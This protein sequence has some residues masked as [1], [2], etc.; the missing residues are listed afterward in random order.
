M[1]RD[2]I[3]AR[4]TDSVLEVLL[5]RKG[6]GWWWEQEIGA[7]NRAQIKRKLDSAIKEELDRPPIEE[8]VG[9]SWDQE[10]KIAFRKEWDARVVAARTA[11][12]EPPVA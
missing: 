2:S 8:A 9:A 7:Y 3:E 1:V 5:R 12:P 4:I 11:R 6:F 10:K